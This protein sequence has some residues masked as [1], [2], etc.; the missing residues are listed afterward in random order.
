MCVLYYSGNV[1]VNIEA[2]S[3][4]S[5]AHQLNNC[6]FDNSILER[7]IYNGASDDRAVRCCFSHYHHKS[8][9]SVVVESTANDIKRTYV[10]QHLP[11]PLLCNHKSSWTASYLNIYLDSN[12]YSDILLN[13]KQI[14][15]TFF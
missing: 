1:D 7:F 15:Q 14:V 8:R 3:A 9:R 2:A 6:L 11:N 12:K 13:F 5:N 10:Y 4:L